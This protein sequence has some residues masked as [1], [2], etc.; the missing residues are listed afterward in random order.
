MATAS[1]PFIVASSKLN[2]A[3]LLTGRGRIDQAVT[4]YRELCPAHGPVPSVASIS[5]QAAEAWA[6]SAL[7]RGAWP[8]AVEARDCAKALTAT[9]R[10]SQPDWQ[11]RYLWSGTSARV[12]TAAAFALVQLGR[13][14]EAAAALQE[15]R[16]LML[17]EQLNAG[18]Q[19]GGPSA[20]LVPDPAGTALYLISTLAGTAAL[21]RDDGGEWDAIPLP[22]LAPG[23]LAEQADRHAA[24]LDAYH[25]H[26]GIAEAAWKAELDRTLGFLRDALRPLARALPPGDIT[27]V[28]VGLFALLPVGAALLDGPPACG[29]SILPALSL[30]QVA[31]PVIPDQAL[32]VADPSLPWAEWERAVVS[33]FFRPPSPEP[34][35]AS[36]KAIVAAL[37]PH[38]VVH[39]ACHATANPGSPLQSRLELPGGGRLTV[40]DVL[41]VQ[42]P[43]LAMVVLSACETGLPDPYSPDEGI[44]FPAAFIA[45]TNASVVST[46]WRVSD[47]ST[48]LLI[49]RFYWEW[50]QEKVPGSLA[51]ARAQWWQRS[52]AANQKC[53]FLEQAVATEVLTASAAEAMTE[54]IRRRSPSG[55]DNPFAHPHYWAAFTYAG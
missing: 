26:P 9:L 21:R 51:L 29:V 52:T 46:L 28:P 8:E 24:A 43:P 53:A 54:Q 10:A 41:Q 47:L 11:A 50:R 13:P 3:I 55:V 15:G 36:P 35:D 17:T 49:L 4:L 30:Q 25:R 14:A 1:E 32:V 18:P 12:A 22:S 5:L 38:G 44:G 37:P 19:P 39:F 2:L 40:G 27:V 16:T 7:Q 31:A 6:R 23:P 33:A 20:G 45:A 42:L 48:A 34:K